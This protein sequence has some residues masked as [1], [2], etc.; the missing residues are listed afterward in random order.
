MVRTSSVTLD[1][2]QARELRRQ[3][4]GKGL[5]IF[6][7]TSVVTTLAEK[8]DETPGKNGGLHQWMH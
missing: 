3:Q 1:L 7:A 8:I 5:A 2:S 6:C 4:H